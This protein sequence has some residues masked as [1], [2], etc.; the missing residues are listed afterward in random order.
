[1]SSEMSIE[2]TFFTNYYRLKSIQLWETK[3]PFFTKTFFQILFALLTGLAAQLR[4]YLPFTPVPITLQTIPVFLS[5]YLL[6]KKSGAKSQTIYIFLGL[7]G[8]PWFANFSGGWQAILGPTGGYL[9]AFIP[10]SY[11]SGYLS[12]HL[13]FDPNSMLKIISLNVIILTSIYSLG[14]IHLY[15]WF[16]FTNGITLTIR[17]LVQMSI[18]PFLLGDISKIVMVDLML[19][20]FR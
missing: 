7:I 4:I 9:L 19:R 8:L 16:Y 12:E 17:T 20:P 2:K 18:L 11:L 15:C 3:Q 1:M 5:G 6:G 10:A 14:S 13:L